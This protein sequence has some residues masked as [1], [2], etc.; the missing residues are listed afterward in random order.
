MSKLI[1][2]AGIVRDYD[3]DSVKQ[4]ET[5]ID[6]LKRSTAYKVLDRFD[7]ADGSVVARIVI[8]Y[9]CYDLIEL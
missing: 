3:F 2:A 4:F 7:R 1:R 9:G 6:S 5:Y 8:S